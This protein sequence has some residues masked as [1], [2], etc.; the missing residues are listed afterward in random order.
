MMKKM[1]KATNYYGWLVLFSCLFLNPLISSANSPRPEAVTSALK[2]STTYLVNATL[3]SGQFV[4]NINLDDRFGMIDTYDVV[5]H[6]GAMYGLG[7]AY[8]TNHQADV[9]AALERANTWLLKNQ[10]K[11]IPG[12]IKLL[13]IWETPTAKHPQSITTGDLGLGLVGIISFENARPG[14]V[15]LD[16]LRRI[17][18]TLL[19]M[20]KP[21]GSFQTAYYPDKSTFDTSYQVLYYP[22]EAALG[23]TLLYEKDHDQRWLQAAAKA[24]N[25]LVKSRKDA[26][27]VPPD[28]WAMIATREILAN[29]ASLKNPPLTREDLLEHARQVCRSLMQHQQPTSAGKAAGS[30]SPEGYTTPTATRMEGLIAAL[31]FLPAK[32][33]Q[34]KTR[35]RSCVD[36]GIAFLMKAQVKNG[37]YTGAIPHAATRKPNDGNAKNMVFNVYA[38]QVR[39]DYVQHALD[40]FID[41]QKLIANS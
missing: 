6:G 21:D 2:D 12:H 16:S 8:Q 7:L 1:K 11:P 40:A 31:F 39:I 3:P 17:G 28:H 15:P 5:R 30:F 34:L 23:L 33:T 29:Y 19:W 18:D 25:F 4:Y 36:T 9:L 26:S 14:S 20:Q 41:Y 37:P 35:I 13:G 10:I 22:G 32:D 24:L 27:D 38:G